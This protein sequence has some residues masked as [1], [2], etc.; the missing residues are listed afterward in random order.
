MLNDHDREALKAAVELLHQCQAHYV[1]E[2]LIEPWVDF[3]ATARLVATFA[4]TG[5]AHV[6]TAYAW[7]D[8]LDGAVHHR[9]ILRGGRVN[10]ASSALYWWRLSQ[11]E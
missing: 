11:R 10:S 2:E 9:V 4:L 1:G 6:S 8:V 5:H 3:P 7:T